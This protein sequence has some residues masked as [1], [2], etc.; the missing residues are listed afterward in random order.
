MKFEFHN[1]LFLKFFW[2]LTALGV[3]PMAISSVFIFVTYQ[4]RIKDVVGETIA[5]ELQV[6]TGIQFILIFLF[7]LIMATFAA[8]MISRNISRPL[9]V[10]K[11]VMNRIGRG[12]LNIKIHVMRKD[13]VGDLGR[14]VNDMVTKVRESRD[15]QEE[16]SKLKSEFISVAAHQL[17]TPLS[18]EKW[19]HNLI[20]DGD[21]GKINAKQRDLLVKADMANESMIRLI[22]NLLDAARIEQ[23]R[24]G[25][26]FMQMDFTPFIRMLMT[27]R[28]AH[29]KKKKVNLYMDKKLPK[30]LIIMAD[31][32]RLSIALGNI[33]DNAIR[34]TAA[35]GSVSVAVEASRAWLTIKI[36]DTGIGI[37]EQDQKRLFTKFYRGSNVIHME[38]EGT[39]IGLFISKN[40]IIAHGGEIWFQSSEAKGTTFFVKLPLSTS[41][42][43]PHTPT[44]EEFV[45]KI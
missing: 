40:I 10:L 42:R 1:S 19:A 8:F 28:E 38:T 21:V 18:V 12:N 11:E 32:D 13:E 20:M 34:Y 7:V 9:Q 5:M 41:P 36:K 2:T 3:L 22:H 44:T 29:A 6:N 39:G 25:Y 33:L 24:F 16:V 30:K 43:S 37:V 23:G 14:F 31:E 4:S 45:G 26:T 35:K 15:R 27:E 17:R